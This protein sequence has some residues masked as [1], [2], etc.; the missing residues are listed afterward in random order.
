MDAGTVKLRAWGKKEK[1]MYEAFTT[2]Y[3]LPEALQC[4]SVNNPLSHRESERDIVTMQFTGHYDSAG[5]EIYEGDILQCEGEDAAG[6]KHFTE[7]EVRFGP[8]G[9]FR[10]EGRSSWYLVGFHFYRVAKDTRRVFDENFKEYIWDFT[11]IIP[12]ESEV[13]GNIF[14]NADLLRRNP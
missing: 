3:K 7:C 10:S 12:S 8:Y 11:I 9:D 2:G 5:R 13:I 6:N 4:D 14:E 1:R